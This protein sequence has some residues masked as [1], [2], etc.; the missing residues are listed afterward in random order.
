MKQLSEWTSQ[1]LVDNRQQCQAILDDVKAE[2]EYY[3]ILLVEGIWLLEER[4]EE[5][6]KELARRN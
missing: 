3:N 1:Q 6:N 2:G 5:I 4:I